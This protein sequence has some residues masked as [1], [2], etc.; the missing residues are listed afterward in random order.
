M[1]IIVGGRNSNNTRELVATV[2]AA[3]L[4]AH[5]IERPNDLRPEWFKGIEHAGLT[6]GTSTLPE[7]VAQVRQ[8]MEE[9]SA[10][11]QEVR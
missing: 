1:V 9:M 7:T 2:R 6:G 4:T 8:R 10:Q 3:G 5:H 11:Y